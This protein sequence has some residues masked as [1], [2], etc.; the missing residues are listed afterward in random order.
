MLDPILYFFVADL[1]FSSTI[2]ISNHL[3]PFGSFDL[4]ILTSL[5]DD[6]FVSSVRSIVV[7]TA[8]QL[9]YLLN[10]QVS[11]FIDLWRK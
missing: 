7:R 11:S 2:T 10:R 4:P 8:A 3:N 6:Q 5:L 1:L 9:L